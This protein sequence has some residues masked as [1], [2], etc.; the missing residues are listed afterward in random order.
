MKQ[1]KILYS[2]VRLFRCSL[3]WNPSYLLFLLGRMVIEILLPFPAILF[4]ALII[5]T[6]LT[7]RNSVIGDTLLESILQN[8]VLFL[9]LI[10]AVSSF[11]LS[12]LDIWTK[13]RLTLL[14]SAFKDYLNRELSQKQIQLPMK[15][16]E[17]VEVRELFIRADSAISG[18]INYAVRSLGSDRGVDAIGTETVRMIAGV[19][20]AIIII[21]ALVKL[22]LVMAMMIFIVLCFHMFGGSR[23]KRAS[24]EERLK[25]APYRNKNQYVT[26]VMIDFRFAKEIR[27]YKVQNFLMEKFYQNK[28]FFYQA[29][30]EAKPA[31]Y[32]ANL[33][34]A[35]GELLQ[36]AVT[37]GYLAIRVLGGSMSLGAFT[38][39]ATAI[40]NLS[41]TLVTVVQAYLNL[42]LYGEYLEEFEKAKNL[43]EKE[44]LETEK[45]KREETAIYK[46]EKVWENNKVHI[47]EL[48]EVSFSYPGSS[49]KIL[50]KFSLVLHLKGSIS[51]VGPNG[52]GKSTLIKL[53]LRLYEPDEGAIYLDGVNIQEIPLE[54]YRKKMSAVFQD[55]AIFAWSIRENVTPEKQDTRIWKSLQ[56]VGLQERIERLPQRLDT[57][58]FRHYHVDGIDMS[59]GEKQKLAIARMLYQNTPIMILDEPTAALDPRAELEI[60]EQI[61]T[62]AQ[63]K[64]VLYIS[65][66]M[67]SC[68][69]C[70]MILVLEHGKVV[71]QGTHQELM[72]H[73][74]LYY[75]MYQAQ[76]EGYKMVDIIG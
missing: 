14:Q 5:D 41:E 42:M 74:G 72:V 2:I 10:M 49:I 65:H 52:S 6:L 32:L 9:V 61:H 69:F 51:M 63:S 44:K 39:Y 35:A 57:N 56:Q 17:R 58:L 3:S 20:R 43:G 26:N 1:K 59:G 50:N 30:E 12:I 28:H 55:Y 8:P 46:W 27:L 75:Q 54:E 13:R 40:R 64:T 76:A 16:M 31:F 38:G 18:D 73:H 25:T 53:L 21:I 68:H 67:S 47:L 34:G 70:D 36:M 29:R 60:Y 71:E 37:Y 45:T 15:E 48:K 23:E 7:D 19:V 22:N 24:Y 62:L 66:R 4:P 33:L 11:V